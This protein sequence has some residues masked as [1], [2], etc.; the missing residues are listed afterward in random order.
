[1]R[2]KIVAGNWK[3]NKTLGDSEELTLEIMEGVHIESP[4][5]VI[6]APPTP[7]LHRVKALAFEHKAIKVSA[8]NCHEKESGAFTGEIS[9][10]MLRSLYTD[11]AIIGHS[12]RRQYYNENDATLLLKIKTL[13]KWG[14]KAIYCCGE[15][16]EIREENQQYEYVLE[17]IKIALFNL[18]AEEMANVTIAY[19]PVWAIGTGKTATAEQAEE[20][21]KFIRTT[22]EG[23]F[24][25]ELA[26]NLSIIYGGSCNPSNAEELFAQNNIDGGLIGGASLKAREFL[27]IIEA[28]RTNL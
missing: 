12:E 13:T 5:V 26:D 8:Q 27:A 28:A 24:G 22:I 2:K 25:K 9:V 23:K 1:M 16:F 17:Q 11:Y 15:P 6:L 14:I 20:M 18:T 10:E 4:I 7:F 3:M 19:E 21:H